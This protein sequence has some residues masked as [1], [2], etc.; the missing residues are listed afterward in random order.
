M[1]NINRATKA[2]LLQ[3]ITEQQGA[4]ESLQQQVNES[5]ERVTV[6]LLIAA[7]SF[8]LGLLF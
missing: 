7:I 1:T 3:L 5:Q 6:A 8:C 2:Q 4:T